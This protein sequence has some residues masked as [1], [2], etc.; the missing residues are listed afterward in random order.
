MVAIAFFTD[1]RVVVSVALA[2][3]RV[4]STRFLEITVQKQELVVLKRFFFVLLITSRKQ[5]ICYNR[6]RFLPFKYFSIHYS[7][8]YHSTSLTTRHHVKKR[9]S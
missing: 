6:P 8:S 3:S 4:W 7:Q 9:H 5:R 1:I 2:S